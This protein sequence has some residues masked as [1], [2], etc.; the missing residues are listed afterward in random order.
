M[1]ETIYKHILGTISTRY[2]NSEE[3]L[4]VHLVQKV[5]GVFSNREINVC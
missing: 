1:K 2:T 5:S 4:S 3:K